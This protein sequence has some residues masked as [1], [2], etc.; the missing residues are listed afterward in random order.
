MKSGEPG[1]W[2]HWSH[3]V[4]F[5]IPILLLHLGFI[6]AL[7][8]L[9]QRYQNELPKISAAQE[10]P[11]TIPPEPSIFIFMQQNTGAYSAWQYLPTTYSVLLGVL[12]EPVD[13]AVR[14][15]EPYQQLRNPDG[16]S[17]RDSL[18]LDY[19]TAFTLFV[20]IRSAMR[21]HWV[22]MLSS[23]VY[24]VAFTVIPAMA[25]VVWTINWAPLDSE[26]D[27]PF[28]ATITMNRGVIIATCAINAVLIVLGAV[29]MYILQVRRTG[30]PRNPKSIGGIASLVC[31][32]PVLNLFQQIN[33][34]ADTELIEDILQG[35]RFRLEP[36]AVTLNSGNTH[37]TLQIT[38][39]VDTNHALSYSQ[40]SGQTRA[41]A[42]GDWLSKK[43]VW[44]CEIVFLAYVN[45]LGFLSPTT[46]C[47]ISI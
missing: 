43:R 47:L 20:P 14:L 6:I 12:W 10:N 11:T 30:L 28:Y 8:I 38:T 7:A 31:E 3:K 25:G 9:L 2:M 21:K 22:V 4:V 33:S 17:V 19:I 34:R 46:Q 24:I 37:Q 5:I 32:S 36:Q 26:T 16:V 15:L 35:I 41:R 13:A 44:A 45:Y 27:G 23:V 1:N 40:V 18:S 39:N 29:L 42:H